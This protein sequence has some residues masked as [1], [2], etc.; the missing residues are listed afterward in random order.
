MTPV[1]LAF[2]GS[3]GRIGTIRLGE[4]AGRVIFAYPDTLPEW[5]T[6]IVDPPPHAGE[7]G[8]IYLHD[9]REVIATFDHEWAVEWLT[10][11]PEEAEIERTRL[12]GWRPLRGP[13]DWLD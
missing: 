5:W 12:Y 2:W 9:T 7:P 1:T 11:G 8:D 3:Q 10:P 6:I 4:W 13:V